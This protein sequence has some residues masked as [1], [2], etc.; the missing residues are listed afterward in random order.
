MCAHLA[1]K[2]IKLRATTER[3]NAASANAGQAIALAAPLRTTPVNI[4]ASAVAHTHTFAVLSRTAKYNIK[5][6]AAAEKAIAVAQSAT[7]ANIAAA[8]AYAHD[9]HAPRRASVAERGGH[10]AAAAPAQGHAYFLRDSEDAQHTSLAGARK[11]PT[12]IAVALVLYATA[13]HGVL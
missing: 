2:Y 6:K 11:R 4:K 12:T 8:A 3:V 10:G 5:L 7:T 9:S 1:R 13:A